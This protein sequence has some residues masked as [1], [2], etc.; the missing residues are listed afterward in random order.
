MSTVISRLYDWVTDKAGG[1]KITASKQD[2]ELDQIIV[3]L[4]RKVLCS[5]S[6]PGSP[7]A[8][9]TWIDTTN[10]F[11]KLYRNNEWVTMGPVHVSATGAVMGT[12]QEGD[13]WYD[14]TLNTL[15]AYNGATWDVIPT[16]TFVPS[17][18][19]ALAGS[20][21]KTVNVQTGAVA[22]GSTDIP[23][24]DSIPQNTEGVEFM[25]L[26]ITPSHASNK[27]KI[28]ITANL[29]AASAGRAIIGALF[30][31]STASALA[32]AWV[33]QGQSGGA[34][35]FGQCMTF[36]HYMAAG[37]TSATTFKF[38]AG[39]DSGTTQITFNGEAAGRK[40]GGVMA[41]SITIEEIKV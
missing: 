30:Q 34:G 17:V 23:S 18:S 25:T 4:N 28:T 10:K 20:V 37:T 32:S 31:D 13:L 2:D 14:T 3:G 12:P 8:G 39:A 33:T 1:V 15:Q 24:D 41:S 7:I 40:F 29:A 22:T 27:L 16:S 26:A 38:R 36:S 21:I 6:A 11:L 35:G 5:G 9:Q 19:N